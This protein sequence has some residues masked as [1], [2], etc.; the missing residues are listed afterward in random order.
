[1]SDTITNG[2]RIQVTSNY[3]LSHSNPANN[4]FIFSYHV[5]IS[6]EGVEEST[7]ISRHWIITN[8]IGQ[9]EEVRG[10]EVVGETP[11]IYPREYFEYTSFC[12]LST[13]WGTMEGTYQMQKKD[14]TVFNAIIDRFL[15]SRSEKIK[16]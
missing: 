16:H 3:E 11:T 15:L 5:I 13:E 12:P 10:A 7:L 9:I 2:I 1:M 14:G 4:K 6:N 8:S